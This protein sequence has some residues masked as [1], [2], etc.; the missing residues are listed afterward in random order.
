MG[1][2]HMVSVEIDTWGLNELARSSMMIFSSGCG[3]QSSVS[4]AERVRRPRVQDTW[5]QIQLIRRHRTL[6]HLCSCDSG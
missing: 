3:E 6:T 4:C 2:A 5:K 1:A